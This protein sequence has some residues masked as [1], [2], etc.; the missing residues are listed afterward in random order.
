[1]QQQA[2]VIAGSVAILILLIVAAVHIY[3]AAGGKVGK[4]AAIPSA[5]GRAVIKPS[6][7]G[8]AMVAVGLCAMAALVA[9]RIGWLDLPALPGNSVVVE[10]GTW[11]IAVVF[12]LR[13]IGDFRYVG[14][15][16]RIRDGK[17]AR[18]DTLVYSPLCAFLA[19]LIGISAST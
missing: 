17:F 6:T 15:F 14:F 2:L 10:I 11:L 5:N 4:G 13:A 12:A 16:K 7:F 8:T 18:L 9:L 1:M 19:L 3:W